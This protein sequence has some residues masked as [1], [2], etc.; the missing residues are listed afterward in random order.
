MF[1]PKFF[2]NKVLEKKKGNY[3]F[4][5]FSFLPVG[6]LSFIQYTLLISWLVGAVIATVNRWLEMHHGPDAQTF[7]IY[8]SQ[9]T[10][11]NWF[12]ISL[13]VSFALAVFLELPN[14]NSELDNRHKYASQTA[15]DTADVEEFVRQIKVDAARQAKA[16]AKKA[17]QAGHEERRQRQQE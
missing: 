5:R 13:I 9:Q 16:D 6:V 17:R 4:A 3:A 2:L 10:L 14:D 15:S 1:V 11:V 7:L 8:I 12:F